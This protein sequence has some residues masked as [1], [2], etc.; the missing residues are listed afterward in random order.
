MSRKKADALMMLALTSAMALSG[1]WHLPRWTRQPPPPTLDTGRGVIE[2]ELRKLRQPPPP[3]TLPQPEAASNLTPPMLPPSRRSRVR[4]AERYIP[5]RRV[6][7]ETAQV[8][9][10]P[11]AETPP[12]SSPIGK[13]TAGDGR[14]QKAKQEDTL[15]LIRRTSEGLSRLKNL[16][17][18]RSR[19]TAAQARVFLDQAKQ[20]FAAGDNDGANTLATKA[21]L[22]LDELAGQ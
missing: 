12:A 9:A 20:A 6:Q 19:A 22:L 18:A 4:L 11:A 15:T 14:S 16:S 8:Q 7:P 17:S 10:S 21:R 1:C 2:T 13:L 5:G 3:S